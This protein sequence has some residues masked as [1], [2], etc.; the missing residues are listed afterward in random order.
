MIIRT[1]TELCKLNTFE[2]R[3]EYA[4]LD[5]RVGEETFGRDRWLNQA[6]Y[7]NEYW[8]K[9]V[10]PAIITRDGGYDL[11]VY[12]LEIVGYVIL[13][14]LNPITVDQVE[15]HDPLVFDF[16]NLISVS[17]KT[18]RAIHYGLPSDAC[19]VKPYSERRPNDTCPWKR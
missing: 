8:R 1:Y 5:G 18:H 6:L 11:G 17:D 9:V 16:E 4:K 19:L 14:H 10:R 15:N 3:F 13:H 12:G 2:E 7:H